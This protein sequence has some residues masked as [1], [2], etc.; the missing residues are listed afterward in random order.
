MTD[1]LAEPGWTRFAAEPATL[2]WAAA[3]LAEARRVLGRPGGDWR[4]GDTWFVGVDALA[5]DGDGAVGGVPLAG[6]AVA[7]ALRRH[8]P[9]HWHPAQLSVI[10]PGYPRPSDAESP[11]AFAFRLNRDAAHVDGLIAEGPDKRRFVREPHAFVLGI[12]LNDC[13]AGASPLAVWDGSHRIMAGMFR[14]ALAGAAPEAMGDRDVTEAYQAARRQ[15]FDTCPRRLLPLAAGEAI[16]MDRHL[17]HGVSPWAE[18]ATA[19]PEGRIIAYFRP[20][21]PTVAVWAGL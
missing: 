11:A 6:L 3:A 8:G 10:R 19:P 15:A 5:N 16:L 4:A 2:R 18:G 7:K 20:E 1:A 13:G 14:Q 17:L 9:Q 21:C 12:A